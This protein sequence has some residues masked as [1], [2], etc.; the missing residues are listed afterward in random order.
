MS[1]ITLG[2]AL[3]LAPALDQFAAPPLIPLPVDITTNAGRSWV[4]APRP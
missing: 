1:R 4:S 3:T 2:L